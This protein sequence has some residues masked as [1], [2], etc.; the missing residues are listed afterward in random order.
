M[1]RKGKFCAW[2]A[3]VHPSFIN[4]EE[5]GYQDLAN[6]FDVLETELSFCTK[7]FQCIFRKL[8]RENLKKSYS[9][10]HTT[11]I[12]VMNTWGL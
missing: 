3:M 12:K 1:L 4:S 7:T 10:T 8:L 9:K 11:F 5:T 2:K 6:C